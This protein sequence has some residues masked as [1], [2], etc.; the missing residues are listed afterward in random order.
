[1][2]FLNNGKGGIN[3]SDATATADDIIAPKTAYVKS[4]KIEGNMIATYTP[5]ESL[6]NMSTIEIIGNS[7]CITRDKKAIIV[8]NDSDINTFVFNDSLGIYE[9][10]HTYTENQ[11]G[12]VNS[13]KRDFKSRLIDC[14]AY[15]PNTHI[16]YVAFFRY[17]NNMRVITFNADTGDLLYTGKNNEYVAA[18]DWFGEGAENFPMMYLEPVYSIAFSQLNPNILYISCNNGFSYNCTFWSSVTK[19][20]WTNGNT[21]DELQHDFVG[22]TTGDKY[23]ITDNNISLLGFSQTILGTI[24][25]GANIAINPDYTMMVADGKLYSIIESESSITKDKE[26]PTNISLFDTKGMWLSTTVFCQLNSNTLYVY[27]LSNTSDIKVT[28]FENINNFNK[29]RNEDL[30]GIS[31]VSNFSKYVTVLQNKEDRFAR[32][33]SP[34]YKTILYNTDDSD[35]VEKDILLGKVV[36]NNDGKK[37]GAMPDNGEL[38]YTPS[39]EEQT[40]P[41][42]Y[43]SGGRV[44]PMDITKTQEYKECLDLSNSIL[45]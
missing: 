27:E 25:L 38:T 17:K 20:E 44:L 3:T 41:E 18:R 45:S 28:T 24:T 35:G 19:K 15:E 30:F 5:R 6:L 11:L 23:L 1:M 32:L 16:C 9:I 21:F 43:I 36:Y 26:L 34:S 42:G 10:K 12:I 14:S 22:T 33:Y 13:G 8:W 40:I 37:I 31:S 4:R 7:A 39:E 29:I 2:H